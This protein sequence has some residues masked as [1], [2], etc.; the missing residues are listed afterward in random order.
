MVSRV[1]V[2][3]LALGAAVYRFTTGAVLE[4]VGLLGLAS[5]LIFLKA[6]EKQPALKRYA[7]LSFFTTAV[8]VGYVMY[9]NSR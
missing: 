7:Y 8:I 2:I 9:R 3:I 4:A 1:F 6:A 5:G